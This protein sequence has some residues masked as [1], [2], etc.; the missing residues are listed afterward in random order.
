MERESFEHLETAQLMNEH[1]VCVKVDREERPDVDDLT[2]AATISMTGRGGWPTSVFLEPQGLRP[3]YCGTYFPREGRIAGVPTFRQVLSGISNAWQ[4]QRESVLAQAKQLEDAVR[5]QLPKLGTQAKPLTVQTIAS[6]VQTLLAIFDKQH[7]GFGQAP[8]FPQAVFLEFLLDARE[9]VDAETKIAVDAALRTT[10]DAMA[11]GGL[12]DHL[13]GGFHR[14]SVDTYWTVPHFEKMLYDQAQLLRVYARASSVF[15]DAWYA[16]VARGVVEHIAQDLLQ[17]SGLLS[18]ALDAESEH[19]E[20]KSY[21]WTASEAQECLLSGGFDAAQTQ[22]VMEALG[23][24]GNPNFVD[25]H[26]PKDDPTWVLRLAQRPDAIAAKAGVDAQAFAE[27]LARANSVLLIRRAAR[28]Q[29]GTDDKA[30]A[31]WNG[32]AIDALARAGSVLEFRAATEIASDAADAMLSM[33]M[34]EHE[35]RISATQRAISQRRARS[36]RAVRDEKGESTNVASG[37][38]F[39]E[40]AAATATGLLSLARSAAS[41]TARRMRLQQARDVLMEAMSFEGDAHSDNPR[42]GVGGSMFAG[43]MSLHDGAMPSGF[44]LRLHALL[45][46]YEL[47]D[48]ANEKEQLASVVLQ[49]LSGASGHIAAQPV[50]CINAVRALLRVHRMMPAHA[51]Q[52]AMGK[53]AANAGSERVEGASNSARGVM[54]GSDVVEVFSQTEQVVLMRDEPAELLLHIGI[55]P[56]YHIVAAQ[57]YEEGDDLAAQLDGLMPLRVG[58]F[59]GSG[60][61]AYADYPAGVLWPSEEVARATGLPRIRVLSGTIELRVALER[62]GSWEGNPLLCVQFQACSDRECLAPS[63]V[64]LDIALVKG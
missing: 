23:L 34:V 33:P 10:L 61:A 2:M 30:I 14:Y 37:Q 5:E 36:W 32:L 39:L 21:V 51:V 56:G 64:E 52:L 3:F 19:R 47:T 16:Q 8:K 58:V 54:Q 27:L 41:A 13:G 28:V 15:G 62:D 24:A 50:G 18:S 26:H 46:L 9:V 38:G 1:F 57:P 7:G 43:R 45:D 12:H 40:D 29:P 44:S 48:D 20:G 11:M 60:V 49:Q 17:P 31:C 25:P 55:A 35:T 4:T 22:V 53:G 42:D 6:C 63:F 59:H